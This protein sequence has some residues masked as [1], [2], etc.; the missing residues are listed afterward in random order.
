LTEDRRG[1]A[2]M[3]YAFD[4]KDDYL[5]TVR[6]PGVQNAFSLSVW[7]RP[8]SPEARESRILDW[9]MG[10]HEQILLGISGLTAEDPEQ[11]LY[12]SI[13]GM[14]SGLS[15]KYIR[16]NS[17][18]GLQ[19]A[20]WYHGGMV[21][22]ESQAA[23]FSEDGLSLF[24]DGKFLTST[25]KPDLYPFRNLG[26]P[27]IGAGKNLQQDHFF[28]GSID[29]LRIYDRAL[30]PKDVASLYQLDGGSPAPDAT[31]HTN[32][33]YYQPEWGWM[34]TDPKTFPNLYRS[35]PQDGQGVWLS[36][37]E[38]SWPPSFVENA[39]GSLVTPAK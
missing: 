29:D 27:V 31:P 4:G 7:F 37:S 15:K 19:T 1:R 39:T 17:P 30:S 12:A 21:Y 2:R 23:E 33:W 22:G 34:W 9:T 24:L 18:L 28:H 6:M 11:R 25:K 38:G 36:F 20:R 16:S 14:G 26:H 10:L 32:G 3:A 13:S 35:S 5:D 8:N